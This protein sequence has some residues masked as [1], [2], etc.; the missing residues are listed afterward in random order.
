MAGAIDPLGHRKKALDAFLETKVAKGYRIE[1]HTDTH[2]IIVVGGRP[3][4]LWSR[5]RKHAAGSRYVVSVDE[6]GE[7]TMILAEPKRS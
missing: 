6:H 2:A 3:K 4:P 5:F 7:V 1:T